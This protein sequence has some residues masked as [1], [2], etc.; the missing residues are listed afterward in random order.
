[1]VEVSDEEF[2]KMVA[3]SLDSISPKYQKLLKNVAIVAEE[4]PSPAQLQR[5]KIGSGQLLLGLHEGTS[6]AYQAGTYSGNLPDKITIFKRPHQLISADTA[7]L[8]ERVR[9]TLWHEVAH[10]YG[11]GHDRIHELEK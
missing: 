4:I 7:D 11:L 2:E 1:M 9:H 10:Y 8:K 3:D 5:Q 6:R